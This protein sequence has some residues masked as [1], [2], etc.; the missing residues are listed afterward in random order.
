MYISKSFIPILKNNPSEAKIKSHQLM[1]RVGMIKQSSS[2]IYSWLPLGLKV[3]KKIEQIVRH[4]QDKIGAQEILMPTIQSSD[5]WKESGRYEDYG[6]EMLRIKDRQNREMLYGPTNEELVTD[7]F[8]TSVK[9]Y[10]SLPQLLYH[11]QWKF[12]DEIRPRFGIMRCREFFMKDAYSFDIS[13]EDAIFS[14]NKFFL[15]YLKTFKRLELVA[16]PMAA[17]TGPI[18]GNLSHEFIILADTGESKI[19][20]DK[21]I[22]DLEYDDTKLEKKSLENLRKKYEQ[23]YSVTDEKFNEKE[24]EKKVDAPHRLKTK[25]IE[26]GH[27]FY[28]SDKYSKPMNTAVDLP[29]GKKDFVKMG[30]Y[31]IGVSRLVGAIIEAKYDEKNEVMKWPIS[32]APY[33]ISIIPLTNK[34][35]NSSLDKANK[36]FLELEKNDIDA[37]IDDTDENISAKIKKMNLIGAPFQII[38]GKNSDDDFLEFKEVDKEIKKIHLSEIIKIIKKQKEKN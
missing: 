36:I 31:G 21:R 13:D 19:F 7:I 15:S 16:I 8:R 33:D 12:R 29:G 25:G 34:N 2:G 32:V 24:F 37:I 4:E 14:Y 3:M 1:L 6:D 23:F 35:D 17:D 5:I 38:I 18:G 22:F 10:K 20:T 11:I 27:I 26:V 30:S 9:S 28:F